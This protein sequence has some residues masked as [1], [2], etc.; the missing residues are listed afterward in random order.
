MFTVATVSNSAAGDDAQA[1]RPADGPI[2]LF[3]GKD[4]NGF[5][6]WLRDERYEDPRQVFSV[7]DGVLHISGDGLGYLIT[8][9]SYRDYHLVIEF[10][11]G[12]RTWANRKE[13]ARDSG[14]LFH[15]HGPDGSYGGTWIASIEAQIIEGGVG[16]LLV[17]T[18]K[19][20]S[21]GTSIPTSLA[22]RV[23]RDRDGEPVW[24]R[25]GEPGGEEAFFTSGR[26]NWYGRDPD[27]K[28]EVGSAAATTSKA[29][30]VNGPAW[31]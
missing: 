21:D 12:E 5:Y 17:L 20:P 22:A 27:W 7:R 3:N 6:T 23:V 26:I 25:Q 2:K 28:D 13:S 11:W 1:I 30:V 24:G 31:T 10:K 9:K 4:L 19:D 8:E 18:G 14:V 29:P 15:C 16:D